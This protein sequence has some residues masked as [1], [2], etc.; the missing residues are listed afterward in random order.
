M[1][2]CVCEYVNVS[3]IYAVW[4]MERRGSRRSSLGAVE[5]IYLEDYSKL[6][7]QCNRYK[8]L[9][10]KMT[11]SDNEHFELIILQIRV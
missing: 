4:W 3:G 6:Q 7:K 5:G 11:M 9:S 10:Q 1:H 8:I 2:K